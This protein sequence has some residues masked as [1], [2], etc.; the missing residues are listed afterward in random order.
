V[1]DDSDV[2]ATATTDGGKATVGERVGD[3]LRAADATVALAEGH[4]GGRV[5]ATLTAVPGASDYVERAIVP[6]SY[7]SIRAELG[8]SR[9][10]LDEHGVVSEPV[11]GAMARAAR[12][13]ADAT[14]GV[15]TTGVAGPSGGDES[16]PVGT[17]F[18]GVAYA[19]PWG[20]NASFAEVTRSVLD[21]DRR[22][23]LRA[24]AETALETLAEAIKR[25]ERDGND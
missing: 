8:V 20:S 15:A 2:A 9:E 6:Y 1:S 11:T 7:D 24:A 14:W 25:V 21:G 17:T 16:R 10:L 18:V 3:R 4:T 19:A 23:V 12:D 13:V 22:A 5:T